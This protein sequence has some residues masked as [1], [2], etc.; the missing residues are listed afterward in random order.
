LA[1]D[2]LG[3]LSEK[4]KSQAND[5]QNLHNLFKEVIQQYKEEKINEKEFFSNFLTYL[6]SFSATSFLTVRVLLELKSAIEK[7]TSIKDLTGGTAT[8]SSSTT[9]VPQA[10]FGISGFIN[11]GGNVGGTERERGNG[12]YTLPKP[13]QQQQRLNNDNNNEP[14]PEPIIK[15]QDRKKCNVCSSQILERAKFCSKCGT[16]QS[17]I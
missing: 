13:Q 15:I 3:A 1:V 2:V 4:L 14:T 10:G 16:E 5:T 11:P 12:E 9:S 17:L 6:V 8:P 7:G